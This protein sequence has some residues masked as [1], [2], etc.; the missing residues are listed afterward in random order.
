M[1][2]KK[3]APPR[4]V[5]HTPRKTVAVSVEIYEFVEEVRMAEE[6]RL[7][8]PLP[9]GEFFASMAQRGAQGFRDANK[10]KGK[11]G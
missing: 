3:K 10:A 8:V 7:G 9:V 1:T 5:G 6:D 2:S 4:N 11:R